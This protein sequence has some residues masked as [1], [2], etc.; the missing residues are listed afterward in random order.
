MKKRGRRSEFDHER[1][2]GLIGIA[3]ATRDQLLAPTVPLFQEFARGGLEVIGSGV[4]V[5]LGGMRF[6]LTAGQVLDSRIESRLMVGMST[7]LLSL[8]G[9]PTRFRSP[10]LVGAT[11]DRFDLGIVRLQGTDWNITSLDRFLAFE[12]FDTEIPIVAR[13]SYALVGYPNSMNRFTGNSERVTARAISIGLLECLE[14]DYEETGTNPELNVMLGL[15]KNA[16]WPVD[17]QRTIRDL[18]GVSGGGLWRYGRRIRDSDGAP[19]LSA[20]AIE[21]H[22]K[23]RHRHVLG[24]RITAVVSALADKYPAVR[25]LVDR[26]LGPENSEHA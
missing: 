13:Q 1:T 11:G 5:V 26:P 8:A 14:K 4:L 18:N 20:I 16:V 9:E 6:L 22:K 17:G 15:E 25:E 7:G 12:R 24:T 2:A 23:G 3:E 19:R 21:W 10:G